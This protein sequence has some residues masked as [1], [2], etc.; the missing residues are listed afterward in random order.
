MNGL[1]L[2]DRFVKDAFSPLAEGLKSDFLNNFDLLR[3]QYSIYEK[4]G[5]YVVEVAIPGLSSEEVKIN[6]DKEHRL[7]KISA[8]KVEEEKEENEGE[9]IWHHKGNMNRSFSLYLPKNVI[10]ESVN[11]DSAD[12]QVRVSFDLQDPQELE[13]ERMIEVPILSNKA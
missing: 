5:K 1:Q 2:V 6:V 10:L 8:K 7:L 9:V 13:K 12:G 4:E 11:A 3:D